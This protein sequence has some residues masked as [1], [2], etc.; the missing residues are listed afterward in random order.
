MKPQKLNVGRNRSAGE[1][2][3][4]ALLRV[5]LAAL[6]ELVFWCRY[7]GG[8]GRRPEVREVLG[9]RCPDCDDARAAI[10]KLEV[11]LLNE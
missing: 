7:C 11:R 9:H 8:S 6:E 2:L 10:T 4:V 5:A 3:D 1:A